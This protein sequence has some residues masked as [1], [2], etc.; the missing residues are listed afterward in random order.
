MALNF[1]SSEVKF[2]EKASVE[3]TLTDFSSPSS[4]EFVTIVFAAF[5]FCSTEKAELNP[6]L[7]ASNAKA[8][9]PEKMSRKVLFSKFIIEKRV[10]KNALLTF[11]SV[12]LKPVSGTFINLPHKN[13]EEILR[14]IISKRRK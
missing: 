14:F 13:P 10:L 1:C 9:L 4:T 2:N 7:K 6:R 12:G 3:R 8:P 5:L 11:S